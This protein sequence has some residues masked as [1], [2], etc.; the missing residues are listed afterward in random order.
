MVATV[1]STS[2]S[3]FR[4]LR[5]RVDSHLFY[6]SHICREAEPV[7]LHVDTATASLLQRHPLEN[8]TIHGQQEGHEPKL[9]QRYSLENH[10]IQGRNVVIN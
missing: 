3:S 1:D 10:S 9:E 6:V 4:R 7:Q 2:R 8:D 5:Y